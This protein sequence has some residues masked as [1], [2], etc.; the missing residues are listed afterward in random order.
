MGVDLCDSAYRTLIG[1]LCED[2]ELHV[3]GIFAIRSVDI[4]GDGTA[5]KILQLSD[6]LEGTGYAYVVHTSAA[7]FAGFDFG[8]GCGSDKYGIKIAVWKGTGCCSGD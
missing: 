3:S 8:G 2:Y 1:K 5:G 7:I 6:A 4:E